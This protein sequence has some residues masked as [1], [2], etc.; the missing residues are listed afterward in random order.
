MFG[1]WIKLAVPI[2]ARNIDQAGEQIKS[3]RAAGADI[4]ELRTDYLENLTVDLVKEL[5]AEVKSAGD[6][7]LPVIVTC[8]DKMQGGAIDYPQ[9]LRVEVLTA[10]LKAG[11]EFIDFDN[12]LK[13]EFHESK[14]TSDARLL[15]YRELDEALGLISMIHFELRDIRTDKNTHH[16]LAALL[17]QTNYSRLAG[18]YDINDTELMAV[19]PAM[20]HVAV[21]RTIE[22]SAASKSIVS[23]FEIEILAQPRIL[24]FLM[25]TS[26]MWESFFPSWL[27]CDELSVEIEQCREV[28]QKAR[29]IGVVD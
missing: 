19:D 23:R 10:A 18:Y 2:A 5:I 20:R 11:A 24:E 13:L 16:G 21:G 25:N 8:R 9:K 12:K 27:H 29:Y 28:L 4:I 14:I 22:G 3:A 17:R 15:A 7:K 26:G 1:L 6:K